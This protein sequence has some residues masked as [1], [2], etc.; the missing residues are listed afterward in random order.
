MPRTRPST[1]LIAATVA[2]AACASA[3]APQVAP[4]SLVWPEAPE[5]ARIAFVQSIAKPDDLGIDKGFWR[6]VAEFF[7]GATEERLVRPMAVAR[8]TDGVLYVA[9]PGAKG[10][11]RFD[12]ERRRYQLVQLD[13]EQPLP[14]PVGLA[15]GAGGAMYVADSA[16]KQVFVLT[17]AANVARALPLAGELAQPTGLAFDAE[18]GELYVA[19]TTAHAVKV[20]GA[21]GA[22]RRRFGRRGDAPGEFNF[23]TLLWR[24]ASGRLFVTDSLNFRIQMFDR[25]GRLLGA[26]G[27]LGDATGNLSRPKGVAA[28][29]HGHVYVVD[30]MFH[31][32]QVF[33]TAG[34]FLLSVGRQ[35][36]GAGEFW[37]PTGIFVGAQDTIYVADSHNQRVQVFRYLGDEP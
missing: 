18:A 37:L 2:L 9:D 3:P 11:H 4:L 10:V 35:G 23:P 19:D 16:L 6:R 31:A 21:D 36:R 7:V 1:I 14:S 34:A 17:R 32:F 26:F 29:P 5:P 13:D 27:A 28:D 30:S 20:F 25:D 8:A 15:A 33:D 24:D 22:L 12:V